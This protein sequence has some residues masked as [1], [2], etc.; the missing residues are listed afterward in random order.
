MIILFFDTKSL[1]KYFKYRYLPTMTNQDISIMV[2][3]YL[4]E[5]EHCSPFLVT[6]F[7]EIELCTSFQITSIGEYNERM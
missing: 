3:E 6:A 2:I 7:E 5:I 4:V 1:I